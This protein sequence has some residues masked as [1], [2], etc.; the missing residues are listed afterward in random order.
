MVSTSYYISVFYTS[1]FSFSRLYFLY[2]KHIPS[3]KKIHLA[4]KSMANL[5]SDCT[6]FNQ[7]DSN[8][9][10]PHPSICTSP[11]NFCYISA[12]L[13]W[14][15]PTIKISVNS[16][17][18][19]CVCGMAREQINESTNEQIKTRTKMICWTN[20]WWNTMRCAVTRKKFVKCIINL[21]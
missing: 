15:F 9:I 5:I 13:H 2:K 21:M 10:H 14:L 3:L 12:A 6:I 4:I 11:L 19:V 16:I 1:F 17:W 20:E 7:I 8:R 18:C